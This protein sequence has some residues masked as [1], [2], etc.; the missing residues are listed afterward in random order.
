M[1]QLNE[2]INHHWQ[3]SLA[4]IVVLVIT[5]INELLSKKSKAKEVTPQTVVDMMN[6]QEAV[7]IDIRDKDSFKNGHIIDAINACADD[8]NQPKMEKYKNKP[9]I[10]VCNRGIQANTVAAKIR[11]QGFQPLVLSGGMGSWLSSE[12]PLVKDKAK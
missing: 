1:N 12:L 3:L 2:F 6:N 9:I 8:F 7:V 11:T 4:F 10:L 5:I